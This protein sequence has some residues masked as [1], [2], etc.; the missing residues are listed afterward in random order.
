MGSNGQLQYHRKYAMLTGT[1]GA[2]S[3]PD[4]RGIQQKGSVQESVP[5]LEDGRQQHVRYLKASSA[6]DCLQRSVDA[7]HTL[8]TDFLLAFWQ[9]SSRLPCLWG[10]AMSACRGKEWLCLT[11]LWL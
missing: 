9:A 8:Y 2:Q 6:A 7:E 11:M 5:S 10:S 4:T 1:L 3:S